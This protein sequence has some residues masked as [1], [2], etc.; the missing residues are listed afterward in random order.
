MFS[1]KR[2]IS[3]FF[4]A[5]TLFLLGVSILV[6]SLLFAGFNTRDQ[7]P[8]LWT[9]LQFAI[10]VGFIPPAVHWLNRLGLTERTPT[11]SGLVGYEPSSSSGW[12]TLFILATLIF[13]MYAWM[14]PTYWYVLKLDLWSPYISDGKYFAYYKVVGNNVRSLTAEEYRVMSLYYARAGSSHWPV[15]HL[16]AVAALIGDPTYKALAADSVERSVSSTLKR[17]LRGIARR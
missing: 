12:I 4:L 8:R 5:V 10:I 14:S 15:C 13:F 16:L 9:F 17:R 1:V 7:F 6:H 2:D 3:S 11:G